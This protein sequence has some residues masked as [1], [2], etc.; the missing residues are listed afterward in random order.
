MNIKICIE[1]QGREITFT[2]DE[3][4][5]LYAALDRI[6]GQP[7]TPTWPMVGAPAMPTYPPGVRVGDVWLKTPVSTGRISNV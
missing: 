6:V 3:A 1:I 5:E 4:R 7:R 2:E